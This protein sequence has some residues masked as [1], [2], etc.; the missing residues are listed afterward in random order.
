MLGAKLRSELPDLRF[1]CEIDAMHG[2]LA[3]AFAQDRG[4]LLQPLL[5]DVEQNQ[6]RAF[7]RKMFRET[8]PQAGRAAGDENHTLFETLAHTTNRSEEHTSEL[9]SLMRIS[10]A[11]FSLQ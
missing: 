9:Q 10:S 6:A 1:D 8:T 7:G 3:A 5:V 11:V 4:R 2:T